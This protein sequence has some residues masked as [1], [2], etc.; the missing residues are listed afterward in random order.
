MLSYESRGTGKT[1]DVSDKIDDV[2]RALRQV[3]ERA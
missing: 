2:R 1:A 3:V